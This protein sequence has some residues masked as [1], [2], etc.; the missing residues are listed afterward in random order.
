MARAALVLAVPATMIAIPYVL[1]TG[2]LKGLGYLPDWPIARIV[3]P[4]IVIML[5]PVILCVA[6]CPVEILAQRQ[7]KKE[8][9]ATDA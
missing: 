8:E 3:T 2:I 4:A 9:Q 7:K 1:V 6:F 5:S